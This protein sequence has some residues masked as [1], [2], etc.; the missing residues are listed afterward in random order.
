MMPDGVDLVVEGEAEVVLVE[1]LEGGD[2]HL[3]AAE[4]PDGVPV[5]FELELPAQHRHE[6]V[7]DLKDERLGQLGLR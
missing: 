1:L 7:E 5:G 3:A 2:Q 6:E 4:G